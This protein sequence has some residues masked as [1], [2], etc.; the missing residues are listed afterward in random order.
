MTSLPNTMSLNEALKVAAEMGCTHHAKFTELSRPSEGYAGNEV[1][2]LA[3]Y[4]GTFHHVT[5]EGLVFVE[6]F[7]LGM[8]FG[9]DSQIE[10]RK[11]TDFRHLP[12]GGRQWS[13]AV[14][15]KCVGNTVTKL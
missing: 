1:I 11:V 13:P 9:S 5:G 8:Q 3:H 2:N 12:L 7:H 6:A 14:F 10:Q 4:F 15:Q